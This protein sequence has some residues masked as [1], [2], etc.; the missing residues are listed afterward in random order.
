MERN[1][2]EISI[3]YKDNFSEHYKINYQELE[4]TIRA[5][6]NENQSDFHIGE[7]RFNKK[8]IAIVAT[9]NYSIQFI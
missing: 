2:I 8:D 6:K 9:P 7:K 4:S 3:V 5:V 1:I